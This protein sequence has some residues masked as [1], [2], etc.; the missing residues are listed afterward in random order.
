MFKLQKDPQFT[1]DVPVFIP[2]DDGFDEQK[3]RTR[4]RALGDETLAKFP[5]ETNEDIKAVLRAVIVRFE[6]VVDDDGEAIPMT[7]ALRED[8]I[9][10]PYVREALATAYGRAMVKSRL[11]N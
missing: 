6:D 11:G 8:L 1:H 5:Y 2:C 10:R 3:L 7:D 4:F 9:G